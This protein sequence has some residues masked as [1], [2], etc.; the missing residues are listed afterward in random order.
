MGPVCE[1]ADSK[2]ELGAESQD[3]W[4]E[5]FWEAV[6]IGFVL[7]GGEVWVADDDNEETRRP[8]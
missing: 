1:R 6:A 4:D 7:V 5:E 8:F 2:E 3:P